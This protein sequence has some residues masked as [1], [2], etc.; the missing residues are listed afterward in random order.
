MAVSAMI[1]KQS[2]TPWQ[3][4]KVKRLHEPELILASSRALPD[5]RLIELA[6]LL[7]RRAAREWFEETRTREVPRP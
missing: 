2:N 3:Q 5:P 6:R 1:R 4:D 7:A